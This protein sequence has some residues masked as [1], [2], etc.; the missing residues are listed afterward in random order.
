[1]KSVRPI[2]IILSATA[3]L[4]VGGAARGHA[5]DW[6]L[7]WS[8]DFDQ[9]GPPDPAKWTYEEGWVRNNE[10]QFYT[11]GRAEN[12]RVE[13]GMLVI[14]ARREKLKNPGYRPDAAAGSKQAREFAECTSA[15]VTTRGLAAW[16]YG[17]VEVRAKLPAGRGLWPAIWMLGNKPGVRWPACGEIDIM[18]YVGHEPGVVHGTVHTAKYNHIKGTQRGAKL[19]LPAPEKNFHRYAIEWDADRIDFF[20]DDRKY[21]SFA[22]ERAGAEVWPFDEPHF[23]I[24]NAAVGGSWGGQKGIDPAIFPQKFLIDYVRVYTHKEA[25]R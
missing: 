1:M 18:E 8:D 23:L 10:Q 22:N 21:F 24:L 6:Q 17:R 11:R 5:S 16:K 25:A 14:E 13:G 7:V 19:N 9:P 20:V 15:S 2:L 4:V 3:A 12:A